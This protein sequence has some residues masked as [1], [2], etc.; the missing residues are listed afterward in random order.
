[1][2]KANMIFNIVLVLVMITPLCVGATGKIE[3]FPVTPKYY[4]I[5]APVYYDVELP[6]EE[7][8]EVVVYKSIGEYK[9]TAYCAC[10]AC[11]G[12][13]DGITASGTQATEGRTVAVDTDVIPYG[14]ELL[15]NGNTYV[16]EDC[17]GAINGN[18][19]DIYFDSHSEALQFGIQYADVFIKG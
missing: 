19:I 13:C 6:K 14:T 9:L 7:P 3:A 15:I 18:R 16:A 17:G 1:M 2:K 12:K 10:S 4:K 8:A 11:C 5:D